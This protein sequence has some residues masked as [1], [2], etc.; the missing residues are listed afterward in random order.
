MKNW[1]PRTAPDRPAKNGKRDYDASNER[2]AAIILSEREKHG[3]FLVQWAEAFQRRRAEERA[4]ATGAQGAEFLDVAASG[5]SEAEGRE[6]G[7][8]FAHQRD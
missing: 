1:R 2:A 5:P 3:L 7:P 8:L 6:Y 4:M